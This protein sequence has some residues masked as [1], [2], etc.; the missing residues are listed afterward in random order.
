[1]ERKIK[2]LC[3]MAPMMLDEHRTPRRFLAEV[4]NTTCYVSNMIYL[5]VHKQ[6]RAL[7]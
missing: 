1:V 5:M 6:K 7:S 2:T 3:D 4:V